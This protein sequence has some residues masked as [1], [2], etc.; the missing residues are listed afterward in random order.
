MFSLFRRPEADKAKPASRPHARKTATSPAIWADQLAP[1]AEVEV[2][3]GNDEVAWSIWDD[4][5]AR[6]PGDSPQSLL[7]K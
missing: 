5:V 2:L 3:E 4:S 6:K 7:I 1:I